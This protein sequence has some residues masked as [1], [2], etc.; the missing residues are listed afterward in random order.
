MSPGAECSSCARDG[1][2]R[3][4]VLAPS[5][6]SPHERRALPVPRIPIPD[7][8]APS[9]KRPGAREVGA[10]GIE[11]AVG[12]A[13]LLTSGAAG[14]PDCETPEGLS[15]AA[16]SSGTDELAAVAGAVTARAPHYNIQAVRMTLLSASRCRAKS[17]P[18]AGTGFDGT[19]GFVAPSRPAPAGSLAAHVCWAALCCCCFTSLAAL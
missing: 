19:G 6:R 13:V 7:S 12:W 14:F 15:T 2:C 8:G 1:P 16:P 11:V 18:D 5:E 17:A 9:D 10:G 4:R 3:R